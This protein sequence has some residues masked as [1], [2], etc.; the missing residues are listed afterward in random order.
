MM[1]FLPAEH[2]RAAEVFRLRN[3]TKW[4]HWQ[5]VTSLM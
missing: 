3:Q 4:L 1:C 2:P 5:S